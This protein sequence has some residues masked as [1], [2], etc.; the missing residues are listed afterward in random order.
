M[1]HFQLVDTQIGNFVKLLCRFFDDSTPRSIVSTMTPQDVLNLRDECNRFISGSDKFV[2]G[3]VLSEGELNKAIDWY[4][5]DV[6][7]PIRKVYADTHFTNFSFQQA[8]SLVTGYRR[9]LSSELT[10]KETANGPE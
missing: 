3:F 6:P 1:K 9:Y 4:L 7:E 10:R 8:K 2:H 5:S